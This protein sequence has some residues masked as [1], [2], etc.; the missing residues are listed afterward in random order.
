MSSVS[1][2]R[3][4]EFTAAVHICA[5]LPK[6][7]P[8]LKLEVAPSWECELRCASGEGLVSCCVECSAHA[9]S[10]AGG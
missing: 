2:L 5:R 9:K 4:A 1:V 7:Q 3:A 6:K 10:Q 8:N